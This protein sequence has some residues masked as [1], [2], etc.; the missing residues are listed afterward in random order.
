MQLVTILA[1]KWLV[2]LYLLSCLWEIV[3]ILF[4]MSQE[5]YV[6]P[7]EFHGINLGAFLLH[8]GAYTCIYYLWKYGFSCA[9]DHFLL[10]VYI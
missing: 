8:V 1:F 9:Y 6:C 10:A 2:D 5:L 4:D 7:K 3:M